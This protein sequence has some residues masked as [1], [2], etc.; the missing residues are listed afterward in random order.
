M[1][2]PIKYKNLTSLEKGKIYT[3]YQSG[4][5]YRKE[6]LTMFSITNATFMKV[7]EEVSGL[8]KGL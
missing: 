7:I 6:L 4:K 3:L 2:K 5:F 8:V 1:S